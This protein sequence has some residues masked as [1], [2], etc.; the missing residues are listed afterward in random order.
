MLFRSALIDANGRQVVQQRLNIDG[1]QMITL[2]TSHLPAGFYTV[3]V[4]QDNALLV[5]KLIV[6]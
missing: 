1:S 6:F 2:D 4:S 5:K 3:K